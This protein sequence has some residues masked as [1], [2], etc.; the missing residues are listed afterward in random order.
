MAIVDG[1]LAWIV[2]GK[3]KAL[4]FR[5]VRDELKQGENIMARKNVPAIVS[6]LGILTSIITAL[7]SA[8]R[9]QGGTDTD[10]YRLATPE[11]ES[12]IEKIA[13]LIVQSG[14]PIEQLVE[15]CYKVLVDYGQTLQRM[16]AN[17]KYD[18]VN[19]DITSGNFPTTGNG[20]QEVVVEL[21]HFGRDMASDAVLKEFE[22]RGLCAATLP[23]LLAFGTTHPEKQREFPIVALGSAWQFRDGDR[24]VPYLYGVGLRRGLDLYWDDDGWDDDCRFAAVRK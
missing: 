22:A 9:K 11:G 6:A 20:K 2:S 24:G 5:R 21:V 10:I 8:V 4:Q 18:Y 12:I 3:S 15:N 13:A 7:V 16:I 14:K 19:S 23:E 17:G 1:P